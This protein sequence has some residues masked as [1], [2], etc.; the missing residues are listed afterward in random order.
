MVVSLLGIL[1]AGAAYLPIDPAHPGERIAYLLQDSQT[2]VLLTTSALAHTLSGAAVTQV[3]LDTLDLAAY[4]ITNPVTGVQPA[5]AAYL[6]YTSGS[7]GQPKGVLMPH[8]AIWNLCQWQRQILPDPA[9]TL[10]QSAITFDVACQELFTCWHTGGTLLLIQEELRRDLPALLDFLAAAAVERIFLPYVLLNALAEQATTQH[11]YPATLRDIITAGEQLIIT[12]AIARWLEGLPAATLH[13]HYGPTE[14]HVATA[15]TLENN[16]AQWPV[17]A[18][19]GRPIANMTTYLLDDGQTPVPIGVPGELYIGGAQLACG[20]HN[21]PALTAERFIYHPQFGRLYKTGDLCR[22]LPDGT[23]EYIGRTDFQVKIRGF[24]IELGEIES[25]LLAQVGVREAVVLVREDTMGDKRLVA[26]LVGEAAS[27]TLRQSLAQRLPKYMLPSAF[28]RLEAMPLTPNGKLDRKALPRVPTERDYTAAQSAF[29]APRT[30]M[31][32][33]VAAIWQEVL[34]IKQVGVYDNFFALGGHSLLAT[35]VIARLRSQLGLD[36]SL[37]SLFETSQLGEFASTISRAGGSDATAIQPVMRESPLPLS[38][39]EE[40][41]WRLSQLQTEGSVHRYN[42]ADLTRFTGQLDVKALRQSFHALIA[43]HEILRTGY[44]QTADGVV[45]CIAS[46]AT[47]DLP[48]FDLSALTPQAQWAELERFRT[49]EETQSPDLTQTPRLRLRLVR[50]APEEHILIVTTHHI[51]GDNW[52]VSIIVHEL[53][54]FYASIVTGEPVSLAPLPFQYADYASWQRRFFTPEV[55]SERQQY[56]QRVLAKPLTLL[57]LPTDRPRAL[58][59]QQGAYH[60]Q[61]E[62]IVL[63][64]ALCVRIRQVSQMHH[65][66]VSMFLLAAYAT[67]LYSES[68]CM[69]LFLASPTNKRNQ[70]GTELL[71]GHFAGLA[72]LRLDLSALPSFAALL[73]HVKQTVVDALTYQDINLRQLLQVTG[74]AW[75]PHSRP[76]FHAAFNFLQQEQRITAHWP[77]LTVTPVETEHSHIAAD[78]ALVIWEESTTDFNYHICGKLRYRQDLFEAATIRRMSK[79]F[80]NLLE[81]FVAEPTRPIAQ[82]MLAT[83]A[84]SSLPSQKQHNQ[85]IN[86]DKPIHVPEHA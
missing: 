5:S 53:G 12:P 45:P 21:R 80:Q 65:A 32:S 10:Q 49:V 7:T 60:A 83:G 29:V 75:L 19:I 72:F 63:P 42:L 40:E 58:A 18:P 33:K 16:P 52:S 11:R 13:N 73:A 64:S 69:D 59:Q 57:Q 8:Q 85:D 46:S 15:Y 84:Q 79:N 54:I 3:Q 74:S 20:Y 51:S 34:G 68:G 35:Q 1:K 23:L 4:A 48:L 14:T 55:L 41:M 38:F 2:S 71:V 81:M 62:S 39:V 82:S 47:V 36:I 22:W 24:R 78:V 66:S 26:Y 67:L 50:L 6:I 56:W 25:A 17:W 37:K 77:G 44:H 28:V 27:D 31:E 70:P 30:A 61:M 43:R 76:Q 9:R 86:Y